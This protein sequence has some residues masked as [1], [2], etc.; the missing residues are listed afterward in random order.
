[1]T[2]S[3]FKSAIQSELRNVGFSS[4]ITKVAENENLRTT[5]EF[6]SKVNHELFRWLN[7]RFSNGVTV[8]SENVIT[9]NHPDCDLVSN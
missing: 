1:M 5:I 2:A 4:K 8:S 3:Q 7:G 6:E 9:L